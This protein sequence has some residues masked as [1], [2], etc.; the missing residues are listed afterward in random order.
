[1]SA[2]WP[3]VRR[4]G[5]RFCG[6][7]L[8]AGGGFA[9]YRVR[10]AQAGPAYPNTPARRGEFLV[11]V[12]CRGAFTARRSAPI[13]S[14]A[15]P[16]LRIAWL[17]P[18]GQNVNAGD[19][20]LRFDSSTAQLQLMQKQAQLK[21]AQA[22]LDQ[23]IAQSQI[24]A[25]QDRT[26]LADAQFNVE[27]SQTQVDQAVL[28]GRIKVD[29]A[30]ENLAVAQEKLKVQSA[31]A[32]LHQ[33]SDSAHL[34][35][36]TRQRDQTQA[37]VDLTASRIAQMELKAPI[38]GLLTLRTNCAG[39][40][41]SS[42]CKPY[43]VGD[44]V[45][46]GM[47]L[48]EIPDLNSLEMDVSLE[49]ADRGRVAVNQNVLVRVDAIPELTVPARVSE[50]SALAEMRFEY[51]YTRSFRAYAALL[52]PDER[53]RPDMNGGMDIVVNRIPDA[54]AIPSK[55]LFTRAGKPIVYLAGNRRYR[56]V[57]VQVLARNPDE[58]AI[59][60]IPAGSSVALVDVE[61]QG[62]RK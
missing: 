27:R 33:A 23:A 29:E 50:V 4:W 19:T 15:V 41:M 6:L 13:Y 61:K 57:E 7:L 38:S 9:F 30:R 32:A 44:N 35:S 24:T 25:Q 54:I 48:G 11:L 18:A 56:P 42:D 21:Q 37:D 39:A 60:G 17:A 58:V 10:Q 26:D 1:M 49:E 55:A 5:V 20:I 62:V 45:S 12:R 2:R 36:L 47:V 8:L 31:T 34:A 43:K 40:I 46:S 52:H 14:P 59:A 28:K 22:T 53:L 3:R 51:P 16:N